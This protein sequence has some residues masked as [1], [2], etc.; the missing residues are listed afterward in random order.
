M[1]DAAYLYV[2]N[3][4][5]GIDTACSVLEL[6]GRD[7]NGT[8]RPLFKKAVRYVAV[9]IV[10]GP[11]VD[12]VADAADLRLDELFDIVVSTELL[13]HA[14]RA[15]EIVEAARRHTKPGGVFIATMAGPGRRPHGASGE[16]EPPPGEFYRNVEGRI[17]EDWLINAG[18]DEWVID[19]L[20]TDVRCTARV[21]K[22]D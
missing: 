21:V 15:K 16:G 12:V 9:D 8:V 11:S 14:E 2:M 4:L 5:T 3:A 10:W 6:G 22:G 17:L 20:D 13:E 7:V 18:F 1:H 19:S